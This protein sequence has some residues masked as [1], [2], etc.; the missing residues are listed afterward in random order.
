[1]KRAVLIS[2]LA[3]TALLL[4][5]SASEAISV[6]AAGKQYLEDVAPANA[7]LRSFNAEIDAWTNATPNSV[8]ERQAEAVLVALGTLRTKLLRQTWPRSIKADVLFIVREDIFSLEEDMNSV[9]SNSS[10]GN[11]ALQSTFRADTQTIDADAFYVRRALG[12]PVSG[13]L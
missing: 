6:K 12:L 1:M 10:L 9:T 2:L 8:G 13:A 3:V 7:V 5:S 4:T 11:G